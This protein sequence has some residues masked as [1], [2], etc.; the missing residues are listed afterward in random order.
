[1]KKLKIIRLY[2]LTTNY[3]WCTIKTIQEGIAKSPGMIQTITPGQPE[4]I[5]Q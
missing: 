4:Q 5:N 1:M 2:L 3:N